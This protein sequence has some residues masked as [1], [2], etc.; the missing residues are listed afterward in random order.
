[1][2]MQV[3]ALTIDTGVSPWGDWGSTT[4]FTCQHGQHQQYSNYG[5]QYSHCCPEQHDQG[6]WTSTSKYRRHL[7]I[8]KRIVLHLHIHQNFPFYS[9]DQTF[10]SLLRLQSSQSSWRRHSSPVSDA[11]GAGNA[12]DKRS[13]MKY[14][15]TSESP[16]KAQTQSVLRATCCL[17]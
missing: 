6:G 1:M 14:S 7:R 8:I 10:D 15:P 17:F 9:W 4:Y 11:D 12:E 5:Q 3:W 13:K 2:Q 16:P